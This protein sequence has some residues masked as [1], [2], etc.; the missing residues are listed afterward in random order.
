MRSI[1]EIGKNNNEGGSANME[2]KRTKK[3]KLKTV[4]QIGVV[5]KDISSVIET[6][7]SM[8]GIGPW[9]YRETVG[10]DAKGRSWKVRLAFAYLGS[11]QLE[12]IQPVEG[13]IFHSRFLETHGEGIHH[14]GFYVDDV[15]R[16]ATKLLAKGAKLL[17]T[18]PGRFAY[19]DSGGPGGVMFELIKRAR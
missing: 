7:S 3:L 16:E 4:D 10:T 19:M 6:W 14:L 9:T 8:F 17:F 1:H 18:D 5:V 15:D 11:L 13:R 2:S 12:L